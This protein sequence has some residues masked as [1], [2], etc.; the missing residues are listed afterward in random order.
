[1]VRTRSRVCGYIGSCWERLY[2]AF[3]RQDQGILDHG[4]RPCEVLEVE[5]HLDCWMLGKSGH[6]SMPRFIVLDHIHD[7]LECRLMCS[8][9][10][11]RAVFT[12]DENSGVK[13][14]LLV[15]LQVGK[16]RSF[17]DE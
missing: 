7:G 2:C 17:G 13:E 1:M 5:S 15:E 14:L 3:R 6:S 12:A 8:R 4:T 10:E 9:R 16:N 11:G